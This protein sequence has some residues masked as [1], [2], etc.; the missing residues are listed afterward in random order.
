[1]GDFLKLDA[2]KVRFRMSGWRKPEITE[3]PHAGRDI[4][5]LQPIH[6]S[7]DNHH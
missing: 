4:A 7:F 5:I 3:V 1:M 6:I 2:G